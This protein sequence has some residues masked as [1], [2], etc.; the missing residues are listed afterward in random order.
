MHE[1]VSVTSSKN[2]LRVLDLGHQ[3][4]HPHAYGGSFRDAPLSLH[5]DVESSTF[6]GYYINC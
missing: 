2:R 3:D 5:P 6:Y 4:Q 1:N